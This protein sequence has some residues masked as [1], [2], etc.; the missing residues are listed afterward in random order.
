[1]EKITRNAVRCY[2]ISDNKIV[3]IKYNKGLKAGYYDIPGGK[4]EDGE[5]IEVAA[6]REVEE[7]TGIFVDNLI[8][9]G[10][11]YVEYPDRNYIL[12]ILIAKKYSGEPNNFDENN[13]Q[14]IKLEELQSLSNRLANTIILTSEYIHYLLEDNVKLNINLRVDENENILN[15][16][17]KII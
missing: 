11:M 6:K 15:L 4:I 13:S 7:E 8:Y 5:T 3:V 12:N 17:Y 16:E 14:W 2:I 9:K 1:M 10:K